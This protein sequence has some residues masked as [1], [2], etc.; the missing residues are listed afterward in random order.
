MNLVP[1][2]LPV[3]DILNFDSKSRTLKLGIYAPWL[4]IS[5]NIPVILRLKNCKRIDRGKAVV[6]YFDALTLELR[7]YAPFLL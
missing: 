7:I 6:L 1:P 3:A 5:K 4:I 2:S